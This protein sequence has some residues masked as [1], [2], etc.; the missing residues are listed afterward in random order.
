ML[1]TGLTSLNFF[2]QY[3]CRG[4]KWFIGIVGK[5]R[6]VDS[7]ILAWVVLSDCLFFQICL[8]LECKLPAT[9][10]ASHPFNIF[11][12]CFHKMLFCAS[13]WGLLFWLHRCS[14][15]SPPQLFLGHYFCMLDSVH[16][17]IWYKKSKVQLKAEQ[18]KNQKIS[19]I[20]NQMVA[21][22]SL[23]NLKT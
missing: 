2:L 3:Y 1:E 5:L 7:P 17:C 10:G 12:K 14:S 6:S 21:D 15:C 11:F 13:T 23:L 16:S 8:H 22:V 4:P 9:P 20:F 19:N 18:K